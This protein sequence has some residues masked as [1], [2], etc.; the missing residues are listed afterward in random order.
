MSITRRT[1]LTGLALGAAG[2][3]TGVVARTMP[4]LG[5]QPLTTEA[6]NN[7]G[8]GNSGNGGWRGNGDGD[9]NSANNNP[10]RA[11]HRRNKRQNRRDRN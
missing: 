11:D 7:N 10:N 4:A 5:L 8:N 1:L 6:S 3:A 2:L 9:R